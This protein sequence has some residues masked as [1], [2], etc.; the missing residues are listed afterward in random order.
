[1]DFRCLRCQS[2]SL[3]SLPWSSWH[4]SSHLL[5]LQH[6]PRPAVFLTFPLTLKRPHIV[7]SIT[8]FSSLLFAPLWS[9]FFFLPL[10]RNKDRKSHR[11][12]W[13][14]ILLP[15]LISRVQEVT[16]AASLCCLMGSDLPISTVSEVKSQQPTG[17][18]VQMKHRCQSTPPPSSCPSPQPEAFE[19]LHTRWQFI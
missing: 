19:S 16:V 9:H 5:L 2:L 12:A 6:S 14:L 3:L 11:T 17:H 8:L 1:M 15:G 7:Q 10:P 13:R 18:T 4:W